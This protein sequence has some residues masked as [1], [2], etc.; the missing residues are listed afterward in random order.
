MSITEVAAYAAPAPRAPLEPTTVP[1]PPVGAPG[2]FAYFSIADQINE[3][4]ERVVAGDV[5]HRFV[6]DAAALR[7]HA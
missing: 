3:T 2:S 5:R 1:C 6:I 4:Y 7:D